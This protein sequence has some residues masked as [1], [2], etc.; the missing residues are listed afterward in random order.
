MITNL[1]EK[2]I[3]M[4]ILLQLIMLKIMDRSREMKIN[5]CYKYNSKLIRCFYNYLQKVK[6]YTIPERSYIF[7][8][9]SNKKN[10]NNV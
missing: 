5:K 10:I 1:K 9:N 4:K 8:K 2:I 7:H 3:K 6:S